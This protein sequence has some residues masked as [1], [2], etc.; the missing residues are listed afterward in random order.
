MRGRFTISGTD[1]ICFRREQV[2]LHEPNLGSS[3]RCA[4]RPCTNGGCGIRFRQV[5]PP[6]GGTV[7][8]VCAIAKRDLKAGEVLDDYGMYMTYGEAVNVDE[9]SELRD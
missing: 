9:M 4:A 7:V 1:N 5:A 8:E 6:L 3:R 2:N